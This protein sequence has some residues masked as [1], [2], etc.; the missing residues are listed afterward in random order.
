MATEKKALWVVFK[1]KEGQTKGE[2][3]KEH[4]K[5]YN[6]FLDMPGLF[7]KLFWFNQ[8]KGEWGSL[9]VFNSEKDLRE[10]INSDQWVNDV[11]KRFGKPE[12]T[13][14]EPGPILY[15]KAV[16]KGEDSW[17]EEV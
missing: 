10:Y 14:L 1:L 3:R 8:D 7:S 11:P 6:A 12:I 16:T 5:V 4:L 17:L 13:I 9:Y 2:M 15:K